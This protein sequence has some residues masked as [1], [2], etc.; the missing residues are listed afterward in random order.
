MSKLLLKKNAKLLHFLGTCKD[1]SLISN[2][3]D[4]IDSKFLY[5]L[6]NIVEN[7][8]KNSSIYNSLKQKDKKSISQNK[9]ILRKILKAK[10]CNSLRRL[11][12]N[13]KPQKGGWANLILPILTTVIP[14]IFSLFKKKHK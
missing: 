9:I 2:I 3:L 1:S 4:T 11:F 7:L 14:A 6:K 12:K 13:I 10:N 5:L 8:T